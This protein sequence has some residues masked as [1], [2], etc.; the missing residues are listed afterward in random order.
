MKTKLVLAVIL[1][2]MMSFAACDNAKKTAADAAI[3]GAQT[4]YAAVADQA[5]QYVPDQAKDTQTAIQSAKDAFDKGDYAGAFEASKALPEK[6]KALAAAAAAKKDE[7]TAK[8]TEMSGSMPGLVTAVETKVNALT[9]SHKLPA[10]AADSLASIKQ[11]WSDASAAFSS[12]Q[13]SDAMAKAS[14]AKAKLTELQTTLG[15]KPAA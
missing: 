1:A 15:M 6:V 7:L 4:A 3:K 9:K 2:G 8:W 11:S 13:L 10:G 12:G 5:N 14:A